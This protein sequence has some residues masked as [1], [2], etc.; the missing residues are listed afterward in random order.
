MGMVNEGIV[1]QRVGTSRRLGAWRGVAGRVLG[2]ACV[3]V[4]GALQAG[5]TPVANSL[6]PGLPAANYLHYTDANGT[7]AQA[8][9]QKYSNW[10]P[11][12]LILSQRF[13][14]VSSVP[15]P[16]TEALVGL[17]LLIIGL[18]KWRPSFK[19]SSIPGNTSYNK[20]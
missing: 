6:D 1:P 19:A 2:I 20:G 15:E 4:A 5:A 12:D 8:D 11:D 10:V 13:D 14:I 16:T 9:A 18:S 3:L 17:G 7:G